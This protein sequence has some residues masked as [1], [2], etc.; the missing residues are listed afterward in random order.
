LVIISEFL[1]PQQ[2]VEQVDHQP[3]TYQ[4]HDDR[5]SIHIGLPVGLPQVMSSANSIAEFHIAQR[6]CEER[7]PDDDK[8]NVLHRTSFKCGLT[9]LTIKT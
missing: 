9:F 5:F 6:E 4:Q 2:G 1:R 3:G 7:D 8:Y